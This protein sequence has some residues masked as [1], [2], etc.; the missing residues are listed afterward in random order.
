MS[1]LV[2]AI[3]FLQ[4]GPP[5]IHRSPDRDVIAIYRLL[6]Q[7]RLT[8]NGEAKAGSYLVVA[9]TTKTF[10]GPDAKA[11]CLSPELSSLDNPKLLPDV[12]AALES[13]L[14]QVLTEEPVPDLGIDGARLVSRN[15]IEQIF[16][17]RGWWPEF[18]RRFPKSR[19]FIE[20][21][22]PAFTD[23]RNGAL[24]FV[25][26][27]CGGLCGTGWLVYLTRSGDSWRIAE[28][29]MLWVS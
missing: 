4:L 11:P 15:T 24:V 2:L 27:S 25:S 7:E 21:S 9:D 13:R 10:C 26:H 16:H 17:G 18:Y 29:T 20:F 22:R 19:G 12:P 6:V 28:R 23:D 1:P 8:A 3:A 5:A 14:K